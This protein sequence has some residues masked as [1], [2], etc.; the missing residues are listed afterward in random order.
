METICQPSSLILA[1][2]SPRRKQLLTAMG[3]SFI[4]A[5]PH[6]D[7]SVGEYEAPKDVARRLCIAKAHAVAASYAEGLI[8][9][10]DT[11]VTLDGEI[12]GKPLDAEHATDMLTRLRNRR[13]EVHTGLAVLDAA[14]HRLRQEVV[15]TMVHMRNYKDD[16]IGRYVTGGDPFDK[17]GAYAIQHETFQPVASIRGCYTNVVG[18]PVC[19]L[20]IFLRDWKVK[21]PIPPPS[22]CLTSDVL[23][24]WPR[25]RA[26]D[27]L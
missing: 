10:A 8:I 17:A 25:N 21:V 18:L 2:S 22:Q 7:E 9:A 16:E 3:L 13:H 24:S 4:V 26:Q 12:L 20:F 14:T 6:V 27:L 23:C 15:T 1:S 19:R 5:I 11:L